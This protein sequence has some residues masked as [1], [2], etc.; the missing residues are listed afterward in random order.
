MQQ[1]RRFT[2]KIV[3]KVKEH[4]SPFKWN[5]NPKEHT[6]EDMVPNVMVPNCDE[7]KFHLYVPIQMEVTKWSKLAQMILM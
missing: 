1:S 7:D 2:D 5:G 3:Y 4:N 6:L